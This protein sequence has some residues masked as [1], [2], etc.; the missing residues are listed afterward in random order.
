MKLSVQNLH[1]AVN[2]EQATQTVI[3]YEE[4]FAKAIKESIKSVTKWTVH[5][6]TNRK[7]CYP[8]P[9][10]AVSLNALKFPKRM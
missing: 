5:Y 3:T 7:R 6:F 1:C 2:K 8:L 4:E 10:S 9:E